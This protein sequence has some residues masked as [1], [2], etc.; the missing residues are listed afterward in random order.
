MKKH[1]KCYEYMALKEY[2]EEYGKEVYDHDKLDRLSRIF[3]AT[4]ERWY[5]VWQI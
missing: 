4:K 1:K 2:C 5:K 3:R